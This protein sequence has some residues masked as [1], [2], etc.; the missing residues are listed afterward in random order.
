MCEKKER[1]PYCLSTNLHPKGW[2]TK[3]TKRRF[4]CGNCKRHITSNGKRWFVS[5]EQRSLVDRLLL[6]KLSL[7]GICRAV[8]ISLCWL[9]HY[10][11]KLYARQAKDLHYKYVKG[12]AFDLQRID[13]E[14]DEMWSFVQKKTN[15][16]WIWI[17]QCRRT[18]QVVAFHVGKR[19]RNAAKELWKKI[20][21]VVQDKGYYH[22]D[23][24][25]AYKGVFPEGRHRSSK[26]KKETN[27]VERLNNT[28]RQRVS[29]LVRKT[30]SFSKK[31]KN[32]IG[33]LRYFFCHYNLNKQAHFDFGAHL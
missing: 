5:D 31:T 6:E 33:A 29:R 17:V 30:L 22:T 23:D 10:T 20:P 4:K 27:H 25:D 1:C 19:D 13:F 3:R 16:K 28:I 7:R 26:M 8:G 32:H 14:A 24:W 12:S 21:K 15:K 9:L 18:R 11:G 2:N